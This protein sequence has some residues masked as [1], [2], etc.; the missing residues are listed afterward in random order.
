MTDFLD[1]AVHVVLLT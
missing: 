1:C